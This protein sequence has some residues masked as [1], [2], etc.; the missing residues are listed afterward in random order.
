MTCLC[1]HRGQTGP[2]SNPSAT[3]Q[4][5]WDGW[6]ALGPGRFAP[7]KDPV[8]F[9]EEAVWASAAGLDGT[10]NLASTGVRS[11]DRPARD[12]SLHTLRHICHIYIIHNYNT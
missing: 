9:V 1:R 11:P 5:E 4:L 10:E 7:W 3:S 8:L 2:N 12:K 6:S